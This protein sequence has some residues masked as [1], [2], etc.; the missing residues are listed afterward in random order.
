MDSDS[1]DELMN[2]GINSPNRNVSNSQLSYNSDSSIESDTEGIHREDSIG[3]SQLQQLLDEANARKAQNEL[4][5]KASDIKNNVKK[6][7]IGDSDGSIGTSFNSVNLTI[8][9]GGTNT[10]EESRKKS[11]QEQS[12]KDTVNAI[13]KEKNI[14][15]KN[16]L[17]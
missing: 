15:S 10:S 11:R 7:K 13:D 3:N 12:L 8:N 1:D 2:V 6:R 16:L 4:L 5:A 17:S 14:D 9:L